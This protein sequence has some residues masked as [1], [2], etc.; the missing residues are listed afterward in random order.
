MVVLRDVAAGPAQERG[1][2]RRHARLDVGPNAAHGVAGHERHLIDPHASASLEE[3]R[4]PRGGV[5]PLRMQD[6]GVALPI[7]T[8]VGDRRLGVRLPPDVSCSKATTM[9]PS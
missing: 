9:R 5:G 2:Q 6:E 3:D 1:A 7:P 4:E 8:D